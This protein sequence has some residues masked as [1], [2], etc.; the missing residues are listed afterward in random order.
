M[1]PFQVVYYLC[2]RI[3][4]INAAAAAGQGRFSNYFINFLSSFI[5]FL[6]RY[7]VLGGR[8]IK[9]MWQRQDILQINYELLL[10]KIAAMH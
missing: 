8:C 9:D 1:T 2:N 6:S 5:L 4:N 7:C 10:S 3:I